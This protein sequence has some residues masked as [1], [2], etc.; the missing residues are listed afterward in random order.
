MLKSELIEKIAEQNPHLYE[1]N[2]E[3]IVNAILNTITT[4]L[5][6]G[7]RVELR[8]FGV[9]AVTKREACTGRTRAMARKSPCPRGWSRRLRRAGTC[10]I[11]STR[12]ID[13]DSSPATL[14]FP[15]LQCRTRLLP[16][17]S[18]SRV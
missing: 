15:V 4:E 7:D 6:H 17:G 14:P 2:V 8:G 18:K 11:G 10:T 16:S 13:K 5:A 12:A 9:F 3:A 1:R